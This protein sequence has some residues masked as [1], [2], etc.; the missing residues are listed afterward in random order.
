METKKRARRAEPLPRWR[1][2]GFFPD[3]GEWLSIQYGRRANS[4]ADAIAAFM[5]DKAA[6]IGSEGFAAVKAE[7]VPS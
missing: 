6:R 5:R 3:K 2:S 7:R 4:A 1:I